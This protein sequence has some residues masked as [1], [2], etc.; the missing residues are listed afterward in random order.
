MNRSI[1]LLLFIFAINISFSQEETKIKWW[2][3]ADSEFPVIAGQAWPS[4]VKSVY[5]RFPERAEASVR[6]AVW[7]LSKQS[8]GLSIRFWSNADSI[9]VNYQLKEA[10][11]MLH[12]PA[13]G[14]SGLD[15]YS[16]TKDGEW[17]RC[18]GSYSIEA[19]SNY[20]FRIDGSSE[21][22]KKYGR[23]YQLFLPLYNEVE[24]LGIGV[25]EE[26]FFKV[27][28]TR[29]EKPIVAYG[30]SICQ[31]ACASRP[32]MAWTNI[33]ERK[34]E[35]PV[36]NLGFS[37]NG[38]LEPELIDL[39]TEIDAKLYI[40]DCLPNLDPAKDDTYKLTMDAVK[41]LREKRPG[42]PIVL[43]AHIGYADE[44]TNKKNNDEVIA[45][46]NELEKAFNAL[47]S[48][49]IDN[50]YLLKKHDLALNFDMYVDR[51]HPNDYGMIQYA[52]VYEDL[53]RGILEEP[54]GNSTTTI[55]KTQSRDIAVYKWEE[56]HQK[57]LELNKAETPKICLFGNSIVNFW[58]GE[59]K[60]SIAS[61]KDSWERIMKPMGV[62]N[63][64]FGWDRIENV[65]WRVYHDELDGYEAER[66]ILMIG[67][68]N[69]E[70][71][72]G[73]EIIKGLEMLIN[74]IKIRQ[75]QSDILMIG[76]LPRTGKEEE[77]RGL[78]L[79]LGQM[80]DS[81]AIDFSII[82]DQLLLK[83]GKIDES[84]F[85]DGLHPNRKGYKI[86]AKKLQ[87]IIVGE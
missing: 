85:T 53:I 50:L 4:E 22:Y 3:P 65:L 54:I 71:N 82:G 13:T 64:G 18:W 11:A 9:L 81:K 58:G 86:L 32:G 37:G 46:N 12:M 60:S 63:F 27:L 21:S 45:L 35:R 33:L 8:A 39:M 87:G 16:K 28:P 77:I 41:K 40:L 14:V 34:L 20:S 2:N 26:S 38:R 17:L 78:N 62:R 83:D 24:R 30:T 19:E 31:G 52:T 57:V 1:L 72:S 73:M 7:N 76:I 68:N 6:E 61:G 67:T 56:R 79:K 66:I 23:E 25:V 15:L 29:N 42:I 5:H 47:K 49:G 59:P 84:L 70:H 80:A 44:L 36:I 74:A 48:E 51:I 55:P 10:I 43:S 75:P 69:L